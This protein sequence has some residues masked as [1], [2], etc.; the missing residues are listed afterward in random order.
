MKHINVLG[1]VFESGSSRHVTRILTLAIIG[2]VSLLMLSFAMIASAATLTRQLEVGSRGQ[3]VSDLQA[4]LAKD[5]TIYPQGLVTGYFGSMTQT[6][7]SNFQ[8]RNNRGQD[9]IQASLD[10]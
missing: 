6:A 2:V 9:F 8:T 4:F 3:D 1:G 7:V 10:V 5:S